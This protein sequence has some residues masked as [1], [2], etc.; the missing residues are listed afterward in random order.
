MCSDT[1]PDRF[2]TGKR[3]DYL[4][5]DIPDEDDKNATPASPVPSQ[6]SRFSSSSPS[7]LANK[8]HVPPQNSQSGWGMCKTMCLAGGTGLEQVIAAADNAMP[9]AALPIASKR[10]YYLD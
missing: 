8:S 6:Q 9:Q 2:R 3:N 7:P 4:D 10:R 1:F 5:E